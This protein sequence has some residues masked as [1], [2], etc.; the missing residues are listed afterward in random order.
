VTGYK[1]AISLATN[2]LNVVQIPKIYSSTVHFQY[3]QLLF[4]QIMNLL[5]MPM[6]SSCINV[7]SENE[8]CLH[9]Y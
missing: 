6:Y 7:Y 2:D 3:L 8:V 1:C 4:L 9:F 5:T